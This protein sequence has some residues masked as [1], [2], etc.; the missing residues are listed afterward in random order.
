MRRG[1]AHRKVF[2]NE[3]VS[4]KAMEETEDIVAEWVSRAYV[5]DHPELFEPAIQSSSGS[6]TAAGTNAAAPV[7][8]T[9][10]PKQ[11]RRSEH[12]ET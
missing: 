9:D 11:K 12:E 8:E 1:I 10:D 3:Y 6:S 4:L 5:A 7:V 2:G